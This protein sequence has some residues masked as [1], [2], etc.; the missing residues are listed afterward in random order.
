M[1]RSTIRAEVETIS[2]GRVLWVDDTPTNN[3][4]EV[5][6]LRTLGV[7]V[8]LVTRNQEARQ[9]V[10][11][12]EYDLVLSDIGRDPRSE[13]SGL[14]MPQ[15]LRECGKQVPL[16]FYVGG[17]EGKKTEEGTPVFDAPSEL[18]RF[19][20]ETLGQGSEGGGR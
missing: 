3:L 5:Q 13:E 7:E 20:A 15:L 11:A 18:L 2:G 9:L 17:R 1:R 4:R 14:E 16:A 10:V 6:A 12:F 19:I 8:D